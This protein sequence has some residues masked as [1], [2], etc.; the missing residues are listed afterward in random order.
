MVDQL[1]EL[2][3]TSTILANSRTVQQFVLSELKKKIKLDSMG[4]ILVS[5]LYVASA[6]CIWWNCFSLRLFYCFV[7]LLLFVRFSRCC[8][9]CCYSNFWLLCFC[10]QHILWPVQK[11]HSMSFIFNRHGNKLHR[12]IYRRMQWRGKALYVKSRH[13]KTLLSN[14]GHASIYYVYMYV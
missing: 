3:K 6:L 10:I 2:I 9:C 11:W 5:I 12:S 14:K 8:C 1:S 7:R 13:L 4:R